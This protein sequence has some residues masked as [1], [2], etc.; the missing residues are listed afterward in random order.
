MSIAQA[1]YFQR[2]VD[3]AHRGFLSAV[4]TL[5]RVRKLVFPMPQVN[6]A[7]TQQINTVAGGAET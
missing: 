3:R 2:R 7:K 5:A 1:D 6:V 4:E